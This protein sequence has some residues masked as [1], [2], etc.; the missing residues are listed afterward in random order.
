MKSYK[1]F[2]EEL[3]MRP[4]IDLFSAQIELYHC[5]DHI[6]AIKSPDDYTR[7]LMFMRPQEFYESSFEEII[8][9]Q[10]KVSD[11]VNIYKQHYGK[12][13]FTYGSDWAGFNIPSNILEECMFNIPEDEINNWDKLMLSA[14][15][16]IKEIEG[17]HNY[18]LLGVDELSNRLLEHEFAHA[19]YFTLPEYKAEISKMNDECDPIVKDMMY[20]CITEYGYAD[21]VLPDELQAYMS[22]GLGK[23]M[24]EM[25]IPNI[26][27]W[28][29]KYRNIFDNYYSKS[30]YSNPKLVEIN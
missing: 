26:E 6:W 20:K 18:Y 3:N 12:Q 22:T 27:I 8:S 28:Q 29:E 11:F 4:E 19:M 5:G 17:D 21:H 9:K 25:N 16:T 10:F 30:L 24:I 14:I 13:Q 7:A 23:K 15:N 1:L 2:L